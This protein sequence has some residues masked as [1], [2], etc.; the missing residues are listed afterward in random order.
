MITY[1]IKQGKLFSWLII[2]L[3]GKVSFVSDLV[4]YFPHGSCIHLPLN[5]VITNWHLKVGTNLKAK[6]NLLHTP[7]GC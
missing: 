3:Q 5:Y 6:I 4:L 2:I 1:H 7:Y